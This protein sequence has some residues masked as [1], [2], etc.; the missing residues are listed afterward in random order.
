MAQFALSVASATLCM[1]LTMNTDVTTEQTIDTNKN[2]TLKALFQLIC[3][4]N[5][6]ALLRHTLELYCEEIE[7]TVE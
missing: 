3:E 2:N 1:E 7:R 4:D 5:E 6:F